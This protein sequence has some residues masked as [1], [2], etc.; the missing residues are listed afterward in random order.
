MA[1]IKK[2]TSCKFYN[3]GFCKFQ[4]RCKFKHFKTICTKYACKDKICQHRHP[5]MCRYQEKFRRKTSCLYK[6][7]D[8]EPNI[9]VEEEIAKI[10]RQSDIYLEE[11]R[12]LKE[13][14]K[15][16]KSKIVG[17]KTMLDSAEHEIEK[18]E[19][20]K[21]EIRNSFINQHHIK[22]E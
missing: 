11:L 19:K 2:K 14:I 9:K 18:Y 12:Y 5:K 1:D 8:K 16:L 17:Q 13:D 22:P 15:V 21:L 3:V 20:H 7:T 4:D 6:H 10:R